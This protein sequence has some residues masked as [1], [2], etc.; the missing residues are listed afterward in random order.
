[1]KGMEHLC[2]NIRRI[3]RGEVQRGK[4]GTT[5]VPQEFEKFV[6]LHKRLSEGINDIVSLE[7]ILEEMKA[8][9]SNRQ[10]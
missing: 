5:E 2:D 4:K 9:S 8:S 7:K 10:K 3:S 1:M 6:H